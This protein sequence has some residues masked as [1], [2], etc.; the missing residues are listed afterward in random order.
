MAYWWLKR[1][2]L[3]LYVSLGIY[4][5]FSDSADDTD[6]EGFGEILGRKTMSLKPHV[7]YVWLKYR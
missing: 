6:S 3:P 4:I 1:A 5:L 2:Q 7:V